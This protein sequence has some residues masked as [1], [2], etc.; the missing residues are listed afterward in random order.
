MLSK[1]WNGRLHKRIVKLYMRKK[2][3]FLNVP[4][5]LSNWGT[6]MSRKVR[7]EPGWRIADGCVQL[8]YHPGTFRKSIL[9]SWQHA[10]V[11]CNLPINVSQSTFRHPNL[12]KKIIILYFPY[13]L[14]Y[15]KTRCG[16]NYIWG[17]MVKRLRHRPFTAVTR[18]RF[19]LESFRLLWKIQAT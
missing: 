7:I 4:F 17:S 13:L 9:G 2:W 18:V 12:Y 11:L 3:D 6:R 14:C 1:Y 5:V 10:I 8:K 15:T 19:P 16:R